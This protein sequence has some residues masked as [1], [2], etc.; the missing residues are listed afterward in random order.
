MD[1]IKNGV[2]FEYQL[3]QFAVNSIL[4]NFVMLGNDGFILRWGA[5]Y[6][7]VCRIS[8][9]FMVSTVLFTR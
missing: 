9:G 8:E 7:Y 5:V 6:V 4:K 1:I 2:E 3:M